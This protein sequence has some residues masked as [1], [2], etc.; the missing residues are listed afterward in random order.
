MFK[1]NEY[2]VEKLGDP[3]GMLTGDRYEFKLFLL[4]DEEDE[5]YTENGVYLRVIFKVED[6]VKKI[7]Q[8]S[9]HGQSS[10]Q[11]LEFELDEDEEK[12][13]FEFCEGNIPAPK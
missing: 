10:E 2:S 3:F 5:L 9:F 12:L 1:I 13:V 8:Y 4:V 11:Y 7:S 6:D